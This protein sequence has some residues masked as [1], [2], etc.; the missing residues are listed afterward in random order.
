MSVSDPRMQSTFAVTAQVFTQLYEI[1]NDSKQ[2]SQIAP[3]LGRYSEDRYS[4]DGNDRDQGGN[5]WV[6]T[7]QYAAMF[8][9]FNV[10]E[11]IRESSITLDQDG[12]NL[13]YF[14]SL[15]P[16][17]KQ[18]IQSGNLKPGQIITPGGPNFTKIIFAM[19]DSALAHIERLKRHVNPDYSMNEQFDR[20]SGYMTS[21]QNLEWKRIS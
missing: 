1:N 19:R 7:T 5:P 11:A 10:L 9:A 13:K 6:P 12:I 8:Q 18:Q 17:L 15:S 14:A 4:G 20:N 16:D 2:N 3:A 21:V